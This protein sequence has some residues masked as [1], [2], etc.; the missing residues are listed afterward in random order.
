MRGPG[1][2][3]RA[4]DF[5][6]LIDGRADAATQERYAALLEVVGALRDVPPVEARPNFVA[7]LRSQLVA[8]AE[9]QEGSVV[10]R[11][12]ALKLTPSQRRGAGERRLAAALGGFAVVAAT[13]SMAM[14]SQGALPGDVL[15]PVKRAIE[16]AQT[17]LERDEADRAA[18]LLAHAESRLAEIEALAA[19][20]DADASTISETLEDFQDQSNQAAS[21]A[22]DEFGTTGDQAGV[23]DLRTFSEDAMGRLTSLSETLP[24]E[25]RPALVSAAQNL[26]QIDEVARQ[27]CPECAGSLTEL[28]EFAVRSLARALDTSAGVETLP[29]QPQITEDDLAAGDK[30]MK[31]IDRDP[32]VEPSAE[33]TTDGTAGIDTDEVTTDPGGKVG[34]KVEETEGLLTDTVGKLTDALRGLGGQDEAT[35]QGKKGKKSKS[36]T[37]EGGLVGTLTDLLGLTD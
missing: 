33:P 30:T 26:L 12:T 31:R 22:L 18:S 34:E 10:D 21:L 27:Q 28:P 5:D 14:A 23:S 13:G 36:E 6:A 11:A 4:E 19:R 15:Y 3:R 37:D 2:M 35:G 17:N 1:E 16:N 7:D 25:S 29:D 20:G 32:A 9:R 8:A 24:S